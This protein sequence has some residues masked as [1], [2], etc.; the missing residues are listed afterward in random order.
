[1]LLSTAAAGAHNEALMGRV[2]TIFGV[3]W[4]VALLI[5]FIAIGALLKKHDALSNKSHH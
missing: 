1:M 3:F 5:L 4:V 2:L